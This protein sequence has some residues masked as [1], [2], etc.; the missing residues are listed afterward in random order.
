MKKK[1]KIEKNF[2]TISFIIF[3]YFK[4]KEKAIYVY[5]NDNVSFSSILPV[6]KASRLIND[7]STGG[8]GVL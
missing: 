7:R 6:F 2:Y 8:R 5:F 3:Q 1:R 4:L